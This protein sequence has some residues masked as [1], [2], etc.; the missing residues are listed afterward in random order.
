MNDFDDLDDILDE[1]NE[2]GDTDE[3]DDDQSD[4]VYRLTVKA[5]IAGLKD[6]ETRTDAAVL[7][8]ALRFMKDYDIAPSGS[9]SAKDISK[10]SE[11]ASLP[12][13]RK[14]QA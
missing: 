3:T 7:N 14:A 13:P 9:Q 2:T 11:S 4:L 10:I 6:P 12:F 1:A 5:L 8:A